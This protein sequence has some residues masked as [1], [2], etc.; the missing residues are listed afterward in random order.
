MKTNLSLELVMYGFEKDTE[1]K[2]MTVLCFILP[3]HCFFNDEG[4]EGRVQMV[5]GDLPGQPDKN[6]RIPIKGGKG[7][8]RVA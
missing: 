5:A 4:G 1:N 3:S 8:L 2:D 7:L 6:P